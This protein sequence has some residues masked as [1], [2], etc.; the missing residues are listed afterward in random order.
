MAFFQNFRLQF[1]FFT[2]G[3]LG[4]DEPVKCSAADVKLRSRIKGGL[5]VPGVTELDLAPMMEIAVPPGIEQR[6]DA[7]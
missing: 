6:D 3:E 5:V 7:E 1:Y 4:A 2:F